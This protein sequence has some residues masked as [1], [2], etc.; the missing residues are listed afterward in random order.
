MG[1]HHFVIYHK[2]EKFKCYLEDDGRV[3]VLDG[4]NN[5]TLVSSSASIS[6]IDE[7]KEAARALIE[8]FPKGE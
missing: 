3:Y 4:D 8:S 1:R 6:K 5:P 7:A 2:D